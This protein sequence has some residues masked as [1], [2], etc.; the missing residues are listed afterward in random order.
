MSEL[1][2]TDSRQDIARAKSGGGEAI[3][4][5]LD[6]LTSQMCRPQPVGRGCPNRGSGTVVPGAVLIRQRRSRRR[7]ETK[8]HTRGRA[9]AMHSSKLPMPLAASDSTDYSSVPSAHAR[10]GGRSHPPAP[11]AEPE[12]AVA[13]CRVAHREWRRAAA[14]ALAF[15]TARINNYLSAERLRGLSGSIQNSCILELATCTSVPMYSCSHET[16]S[17]RQ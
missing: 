10:A 13:F 8:L 5:R 6:H 7:V 3:G 1:P 17:C 16:C 4:Y 11:P 9:Q 2:H 12:A 15:C 14:H